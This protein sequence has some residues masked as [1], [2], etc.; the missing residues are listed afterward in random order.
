M[1]AFHRT[2]GA[3]LLSA[4]V[5]LAPASAQTFP[6]LTGRVVDQ[7]EIIPAPQE[8]DLS[9]KLEDFEGR[10]GRQVVVATVK[11]LEGRE[12]NDY[13]TRLFRAWKIGDE[14]KDDGVVFL[15]A[16][17]ERKVYIVTGYGADDYLTDA[18]SGQI[19][20]ADVLPRFKAGDYPGGI[21][22][23]VDGVIRQLELPPEEAAKRADAAQQRQ[24]GDT[25]EVSIIPVIF[26][27]IVFFM[28]I[29]GFAKAAGGGKRYRSA[30]RG[31]GVDPVVILWGLDAIS[32]ASRGGRG[33]G[34]GGGGWG[35]GGGFGGGGF[36]GGGGFSGGGGSSGGGGAGGSW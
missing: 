15:V 11:S 28:I 31:G 19:I 2:L 30:R 17:T 1:T 36:G 35:G 27:V 4:L 20:R 22:A 8:A 5:L 24:A 26:I 32:R 34:W 16:P 7:A 33:G 29:S 13:G 3:L 25:G 10:S 18:M 9:R 6:T 14:Q 21:S 23:G 12:P